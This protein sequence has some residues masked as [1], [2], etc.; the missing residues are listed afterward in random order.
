MAAMSAAGIDVESDAIHDNSEGDTCNVHFKDL[1]TAVTAAA[2]A[3]KL[4]TSREEL[5][6]A[7]VSARE[8]GFED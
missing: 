1:A 7:V 2:A 5:A 8:L 3:A 4:M 6:K